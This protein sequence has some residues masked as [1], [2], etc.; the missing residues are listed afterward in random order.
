MYKAMAACKICEQEL[1]VYNHGG[2]YCRNCQNRVSVGDGQGGI[3]E[4]GNTS[5]G[6]RKFG[7][8]LMKKSSG[9]LK[10]LS[11]LSIMP[12]LS[13]IS[14][15]EELPS[16][17]RALLCGVTYQKEKF[18]LRGTLQDVK[19]MRDLLVEHFSFQPASIL[20]LAEEEPYRAPT[21]KNILEG[22]KWLMKNL[23]PGD[24]LVFY[25]SG[26][27][28]RQPEFDGDE[29]DGF[30]ETICPLDFKSEGM[31]LDNA[32][33]D[34]IVRPLR[35]GI[36]L[37]AIV[38]ACHSGTILDL[39][40]VYNRKEKRWANNEPPSR[41]YKGTLGGKAI[42]F[43][44]CEDHQMAA[45]TSA[46]SSGKEMNGAMTYTFIRAIKENPNIT[47]GGLLNYVHQSIVAANRGRCLPSLNLFNR[48]LEQDTVLSSSQDFDI[49]QKL[50][51]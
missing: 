32:I 30:D 24:S 39:P 42:C 1:A 45:D 15:R 5:Y 14:S 13:S 9:G 26:H 38:D 17:K 19:N 25:F 31:I 47:Y 49:N 35:Q 29:I 50:N 33:N 16:G 36:K 21:R 37:H 40:R 11:S 44:A 28:L 43:G 10:S 8:I 48:K 2:V 27:G 12:S 20:I 18:K 34:I 23:R 4:P 3:Q 22:F 51:L 6:R 7:N 46:F 41:T